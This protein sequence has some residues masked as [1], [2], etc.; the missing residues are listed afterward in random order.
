VAGAHESKK[1]YDRK[2]IKAALR[3]NDESG[4]DLTE[5]K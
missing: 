4:C 5:E 2:K 3:R 1:L